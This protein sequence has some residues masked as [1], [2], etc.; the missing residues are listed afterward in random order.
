MSN[1]DHKLNACKR[2]EDTNI[3]R[4]FEKKTRM[5]V[6]QMPMSLLL[7]VGFRKKKKI[8][9][10]VELLLVALWLDSNNPISWCGELFCLLFSRPKPLCLH[11]ESQLAIYVVYCGPRRLD[12]AISFDHGTFDI[13]YLNLP[14][15]LI[16]ATFYIPFLWRRMVMYYK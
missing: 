2:N 15:F 5:H 13:W 12:H 16:L 9:K 14:P 8:K 10:N 1:V 6:G 7:I 11:S 4:H 3:P